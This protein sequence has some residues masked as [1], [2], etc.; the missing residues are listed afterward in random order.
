LNPRISMR[1]IFSAPA[2]SLLRHSFFYIGG[3]FFR[4]HSAKNFSDL[5]RRARLLFLNSSL[6]LSRWKML[7]PTAGSVGPGRNSSGNMGGRKS[8]RAKTVAVVGIF[9]CFPRAVYSYGQR[10]ETL[11]SKRF[12]DKFQNTPRRQSS[13]RS[14][15]SRRR[16][17]G[18]PRDHRLVRHQGPRAHIFANAHSPRRRWRRTWSRQFDQCETSKEQPGRG[19][20][21]YE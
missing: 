13:E 7:S 19:C 17:G 9:F 2:Q 20:P 21:R 1:Q 18:L 3:H 5:S 11:G 4:A 10:L 8:C 14:T 16:S 6:S 15:R 12:P